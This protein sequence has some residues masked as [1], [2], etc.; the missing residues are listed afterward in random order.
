MQGGK[1]LDIGCGNHSPYKAKS[2]NK[3]IYYVGV[4]I[5]KYCIDDSDLKA[6]DEIYFFEVEDYFEKINSEINHSFNYIICTHVI[7]HLPDKEILFKTIKQKLAKDGKCLIT[8]PNI[9]SINFPSTVN[10][11]NYYDDKTHQGMP[12]T[13]QQIYD[14]CI[15]NNLCLSMFRLRNKSLLSYVLGFI[16]EPFRILLK[17]SLPFTWNYWGFE[18]LYIIEHVRTSI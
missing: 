5:D 4:D 8:T 6:S 14:L 9:N 18:D 11:L 7:E 3:S 1:L 12:V 16:L 15:K 2:A 10:T 13:F 17:R